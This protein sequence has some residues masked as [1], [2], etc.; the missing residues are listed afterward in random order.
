VVSSPP[1]EP[2]HNQLSPYWHQS[3]A[4]SGSFEM[5]APPRRRA[6]DGSAKEVVMRTV[7]LGQSALAV[8]PIAYGTWQFGGDW[9]EFDDDDA[10]A[11]IRRARELGVNFFDTAQAYGFGR[12]E[13]LLGRALADEL[14]SARGNLVIATKGGLR[15]DGPTLRRDASPAWIRHGVQQSLD[16]LG[17]DYIDLYQVH[18]PDPSTPLAETAAALRE[19]RD[20]GL[21]RHVG[22][23][24]YSV[25][26]ME[27]FANVL[28]VETDQPA[29]H[30]FRRDIEGDILPYADKHDIGILAY[31]PL[32]HGLL[33]GSMSETTSF[34]RGDWRANSPAFTGDGFRRNLA[35]VDAL[36]GVAARHDATVGQLAVAWVL[37]NPA[38]HV[39]IVGSRGIRHLEESLGAADLEL[40][41]EDL[42]DI[43]RILAE[44]VPIGGPS[45][46]GMN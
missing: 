9:G 29:Y 28:P 19:L 25:E 37:A 39:A 36:R 8:T 43:E 46:E 24:N 21:I 6:V 35:A 18:W 17:I 16:A 12:S 30:L 10:I 1:A 34:P 42:A 41:A 11:A 45:P 14:R 3:A 40:T 38:V 22:V 33:G 5:K 26:Q 13:R 2:D 31:G 44:A 20:E 32:A 27:E 15:M 4:Q 7:T 23:S